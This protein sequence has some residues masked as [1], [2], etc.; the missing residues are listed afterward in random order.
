MRSPSSRPCKSAPRSLG[1]FTAGTPIGILF[2][3]DGFRE[4]DFSKLQGGHYEV[5]DPLTGEIAKITDVHPT[6]HP[7]LN[8]V[9]VHIADDGTETVLKGQDG[10]R[11]F[12]PTRPRRHPIKNVINPDGLGHF[13][14]GW[15][16]PTAC[17]SSVSTTASAGS[18]IS[19]STTW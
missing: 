3:N 6:D 15:T 18:G 10:N 17:C 12:S 2:L 13:V 5:R 19:A 14:S 8:P 1:T 7:Q 16:P 9:L 4:N 11:I